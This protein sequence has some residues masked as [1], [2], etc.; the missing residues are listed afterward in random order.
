MD[1]TLILLIC[2]A[3]ILSIDIEE[4]MWSTSKQNAS[5]D[6]WIAAV[7]GLIIIMWCIVYIGSGWA[8]ELL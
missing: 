2:S 6:Y 3:V 8:L 4:H 1:W 5:D 7:I